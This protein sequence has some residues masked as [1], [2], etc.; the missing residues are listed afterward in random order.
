MPPVS[1]AGLFNVDNPADPIDCEVKMEF[2]EDVDP[3]D[4]SLWVGC[5]ITKTRGSSRGYS[6]PRGTN[7]LYYRWNCSASVDE[8]NWHITVRKSEKTKRWWVKEYVSLH[9][10]CSIG[11]GGKM[12]LKVIQQLACNSISVNK[13]TTVKEL[14]QESE[15]KCKGVAFNKSTATAGYTMGWRVRRAITSEKLP[16]FVD[17]F[18]LLPG[19]VNKL[20]IENPGS[21]IS[22]ELREVIDG[23]NGQSED[24]FLRMFVMLKQQAVCASLCKPI[25]SYDGGFFKVSDVQFELYIKLYL[26]RF[27]AFM[28]CYIADI[29]CFYL[30][31][32]NSLWGKYTILVGACA[33]GEN[34]D[35]IVSVSLVPV[36]NIDNYS[37]S[38]EG[39]KMNAQLKEFLDQSALIVNTDR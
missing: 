18:K 6:I 31:C 28:W 37:W 14:M 9:T 21:V 34:K 36:E 5:L 11:G 38:I 29:L 15:S 16:S 25:I 35:C 10:N 33:D 3:T 17:G 2:E 26:D 20:N 24:Q 30:S 4:L 22:L 12:K 32:Q 19:Y 27:C 13:S 23:E 7:G 39:Q 1:K 8:C